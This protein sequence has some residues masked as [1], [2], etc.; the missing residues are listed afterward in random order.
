LSLYDF[1]DVENRFGVSFSYERENRSYMKGPENGIHPLA[2]AAGKGLQTVLREVDCKPV[3]T[4]PRVF[5]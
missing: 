2:N 5:V 4:V 1:A 3:E